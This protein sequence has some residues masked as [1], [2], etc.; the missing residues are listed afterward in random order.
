MTEKEI[1][2][3]ILH[4]LNSQPKTF[5]FKIN[6]IGVFD[7]V[8]KI[9]RKNNNKWIQLGTSDIIGVHNAVCFGVE[10]KQP[11]K[12]ASANQ[13]MFLD[14][15]QR[16]GGMGAVCHSLD[17]AISFFKELKLYGEILNRSKPHMDIIKPIS[18]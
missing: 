10:V 15:I 18:S 8:R 13:L 17:E 14:R 7:P 6:T 5:A 4:Y 2:H 9:Y 16:E 1:E 12:K 11:K 3:Q